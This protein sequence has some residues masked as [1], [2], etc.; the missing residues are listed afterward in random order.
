MKSP[1]SEKNL[2]TEEI[3]KKSVTCVSREDYRKLSGE[4]SHLLENYDD[5]EIKE[6][7]LNEEFYLA[8][9]LKLINSDNFL[10]VIKRILDK[11][12]TA[13]EMSFIQASLYFT[14]MPLSTCL[15]HIEPKM[16]WVL[17]K[18][19]YIDF[20][21]ISSQLETSIANL[22]FVLYEICY[23]AKLN[24]NVKF[25]FY[26]NLNKLFRLEKIARALA[27][28]TLLVISTNNALEIALKVVMRKQ[29][30]LEQE[31][32]ITRGLSNLHRAI[33]KIKGGIEHFKGSYQKAT[34]TQD[35]F[36]IFVEN[37]W[38]RNEKNSLFIIEKMASGFE[39]DE[40]KSLIQ[41]LSQKIKEAG[42]IKK[43]ID[44]FARANLG[45]FLH[46]NA[47]ETGHDWSNKIYLATRK[48][49]A[50]LEAIE[51]AC[52]KKWKIKVA[53]RELFN[54]INDTHQVINRNDIED[55][56]LQLENLLSQENDTIEWKSTF[57][58]PTEQPFISEIAEKE[59]GEEIL[60]NI[61]KTI[62]AMMNT[63][64]G[65]ILV[66]VVEKP[67][68]IVRDDI[69]S[70]ILKK[71]GVYFMDV[72]FELSKKAKTIDEVKQN[73]QDRLCN[74]TAKTADFFTNLWSI[75]ILTIKSEEKIAT[76]FKIN[77]KKALEKIFTVEKNRQFWVS[78]LKRANGRTIYVDP[79]NHLSNH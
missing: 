7:S 1:S 10:K 50:S 68:A 31:F 3:L 77:I 74:L 48:T 54:W 23:D 5:N 9:I 66:G 46:D 6:L 63:A 73:I 70:A 16:I 47:S 57:M 41:I 60:S 28:T 8:P 2:K 32:S 12:A 79:R 69:K 65:V 67:K 33:K 4:L 18:K 49:L 25:N 52:D 75:E 37:L 20:E 38:S 29:K 34:Q 43:E 72:N 42:Q 56:F 44:S 27:G 11:S 21:E 76:I 26:I 59:K 61:I 62:L 35:P 30:E 13:E 24:S 51:D 58:T 36:N 53:I 64:G 14:F 71:K 78:L 22:A 55:D 39:Y 40:S 45:A 15:E 19:I 17:R